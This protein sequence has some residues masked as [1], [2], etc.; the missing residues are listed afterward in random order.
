MTTSACARAVLL[1]SLL[2]V[3]LV[4]VAAQQ[5]SPSPSPS[6]AASPSP[7]AT[8]TPDASPTPR[9]PMSTPT[10]NGLRLRSIGPAFT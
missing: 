4:K 6:V 3:C 8:A 7:S 2:V 9:D 5:P 10:F 1:M